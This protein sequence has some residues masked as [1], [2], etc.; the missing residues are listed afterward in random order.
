MCGRFLTG[1]VGSIVFS[2]TGATGVDQI[3][4]MA[5]TAATT[6]AMDVGLMMGERKV[7]EIA[8]HFKSNKA[9][10]VK[11]ESSKRISISFF[12]KHS[13]SSRPGQPSSFA[14]AMVFVARSQ[15]FLA[16]I[17]FSPT[18]LS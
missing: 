3:K 8:L 18:F 7:E 4:F 16:A 12:I 14:R 1:A 10:E 11:K 2:K 15:Q 5:L 13:Q 9:V 17:L 6:N